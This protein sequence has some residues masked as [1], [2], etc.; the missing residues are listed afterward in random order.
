MFAGLE[1][2][3]FLDAIGVPLT[4]PHNCPSATIRAVEL[5]LFNGTKA[6]IISCYRPQT[7]EAHS[8]TCVALAQLPHTFPHPLIILGGDLRGG[9]NS[10][11]E[12]RTHR[13]PS[14]LEVGGA[15][16]FHLYSTPATGLG[17]M[18]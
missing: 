3:Y 5:I 10:R 14:I 6:A 11:P 17:A 13:S 1:E 15:H 4:I 12:G 8:H 2:A 16:A 18:H 7:V 9:G